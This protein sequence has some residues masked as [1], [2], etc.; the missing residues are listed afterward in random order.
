MVDGCSGS[1]KWE[2]V[3]FLCESCIYSFYWMLLWSEED[4]LLRFLNFSSSCLVRNSGRN[5]RKFKPE[6]MKDRS[7]ILWGGTILSLCSCHCNLDNVKNCKGFG[8]V[9]LGFVDE[10]ASFLGSLVH[11][12]LADCRHIFLNGMS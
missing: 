11:V 1:S 5:L 10:I 4:K 12:E 8:S 6:E 3:S 9:G 7:I 2:Q